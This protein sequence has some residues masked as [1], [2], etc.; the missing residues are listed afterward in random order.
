MNFPSTMV[1]FN[2]LLV[3]NKQ[4]SNLDIFVLNAAT[5]IKNQLPRTID[6]KVISSSSQFYKQLP[7][8]RINPYFEN[9]DEIKFG[10][11]N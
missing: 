9:I 6:E 7:K 2:K 4:V 10:N 5:G 11:L 1:A 3:G 8:H